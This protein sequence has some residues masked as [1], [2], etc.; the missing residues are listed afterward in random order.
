MALTL[1]RLGLATGSGGDGRTLLEPFEW[2]QNGQQITLTGVYKASSDADAVSFANGITG[3]DPALSDDNW[4]PIT[5]SLVSGVDGYYKV[6]GSQAGFGRA[7]LGTGTLLVDWQVTVERPRL[8]RQ[9][10]VEI[11]VAASSLTNGM[12]VTTATFLAGVPDGSLTRFESSIGGV[13]PI[14]GSRTAESGVVDVL[15]SPGYSLPLTGQFTVVQ[16]VAA[17]NYYKGSAYIADSVGV[18]H[19]RRDIA[20]ASSYTVGNGLVRMSASSTQLLLSWWT[21]SAWTSTQAFKMC[22]EVGASTYDWTYQ[23]VQVLRNS[24]L[25][26]TLRLSGSSPLG[27]GG[28]VTTDV[29]VRRGE[30][31]VRLVGSSQNSSA[32]MQLR[33]GTST[34]CTSITPGIRNTSAI[35]SEY[36][37]MTSDYASTK[38]TT[39]P[40]KLTNASARARNLWCL[41]VTSGGSATGTGLDDGLGIGQQCY[42]IYGEVERVVFG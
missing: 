33:F 29:S 34:A 15:Y 25:E 24:P 30:R 16:S 21:G 9:P 2:A 19:G 12:S 36:V 18:M 26:S 37:I 28:E 5:S 13:S 41:G 42:S 8:F 40:G 31:I 6:L 23:S 22:H 1:G 20:V 17:A 39:A 38:T 11:P 27:H 3:L 4:I 14:E 10:R 32:G 35:N 7:S